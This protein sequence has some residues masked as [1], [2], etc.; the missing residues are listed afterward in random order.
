MARFSSND[1]ASVLWQ[2]SQEPMRRNNLALSAVPTARINWRV[3]ARTCKSW[4][5]YQLQAHHHVK[6]YVVTSAGFVRKKGEEDVIFYL[7]KKEIFLPLVVQH[8][9]TILPHK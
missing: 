6:S 1:T 3:L 5:K 9:G 7:K 8:P 4:G 2:S